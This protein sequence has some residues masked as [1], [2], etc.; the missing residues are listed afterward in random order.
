MNGC[1]KNCPDCDGEKLLE[2]SRDGGCDTCDGSG[3]VVASAA[4]KY[5]MELLEAIRGRK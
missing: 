5:L 2:G 3:Y 4:G 1:F